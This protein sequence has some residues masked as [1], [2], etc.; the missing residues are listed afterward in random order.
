MNATSIKRTFSNRR[1]AGRQLADSLAKFADED[2]LVILA[3][4][5]GGV[6]VAAEIAKAFDKPFDLLLVRK[7]GVPGHEEVAMGAIASCGVQVLSDE[8]ISMLHLSPKQVDAVVQRETG[9]LARREKLYR[10]GRAVPVVAGCTVIV[11]DDGIAT[12]STMS[13]A[14]ALLRH[15]Q[16]GRIIV[17]V[18]V[19]P[20]DTVERLREEADEVVALLEPDPF[21]AVGKWYD[22]FSQTSDE[23]VRD[24]LVDTDTVTK[25]VAEKVAAFLSSKSAAPDPRAGPALDRG[26]RGL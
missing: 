11:V 15:Q 24:L 18:P 19:A 6:P 1:D 20:P 4:P 7:L 8:L 14:I 22:D 25:P 3:L 23:E 5:R 9:E 10:I 12:G 2:D 16:A 21:V 13:A 17:A 26:R